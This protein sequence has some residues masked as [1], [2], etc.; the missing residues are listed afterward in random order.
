M[1]SN[2]LLNRVQRQLAPDSIAQQVAASAWSI[3]SKPKQRAVLGELPD[4]MFALSLALQNGLSLFSALTW[5][6][7]RTS[8]QLA[9]EIDRAL[10]A[11]NQGAEFASELTEIGRRLPEPQLKELIAKL[12]LASRRGTPVVELVQLQAESVRAE[13]AQLILAAAGRNET[14]M[15]IPTV[16]LILPITVLFAVF[17]SLQA[18]QLGLN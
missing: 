3:V 13:A 7:A 15:L 5:L 8:G 1:R 9:R 18:L 17:P 4:Y 14:R 12:I 2:R 10:V 11:C 16:F 6:S